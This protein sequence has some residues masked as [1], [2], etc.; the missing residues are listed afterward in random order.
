MQHIFRT[1][2]QETKEEP[3]KARFQKDEPVNASEWFRC[4]NPD[5]CPGGKLEAGHEVNS[6]AEM[7]SPMCAEGYEDLGCLGFAKKLQIFR[8]LEVVIWVVI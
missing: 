4:P 7:T 2:E 3:T 5:A 8:S 1:L 6:F